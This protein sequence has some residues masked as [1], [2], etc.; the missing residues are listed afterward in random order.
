DDLLEV[1]R[2]NHGTTDAD[3]SFDIDGAS[4]TLAYYASLGRRLGPRHV[5]ADGDGV[6]LGKTEGFYARHALVPRQGVAVAINAFNF[7]VWGFAEKAACALLAGMPMVVKPATATALVTERALRL[8]IEAEILPEGALQ[9]ICGSTGDLLD[10]LGPQDVLAFTGSADTALRLRGRQNLLAASTH[11]NVEAD[12]LNAAVLAPDAE[13]GSTTFEL[14]VRDVAREMTQK[15]GQKCTAV[16][17]VVVP[18]GRADAVCEA[19]AKRLGR[20]LVGNPASEGVRMGPLA[21]AGQLRDTLAGVAELRQHAE[22][23]VGTGERIDGAGSPEGKGYFF[24]PTLLRTADSGL[25]EASPGPI[26]TREVFG[27]VATLVPYGGSAEEG[28]AVVAL[29]GGTLV[30]SAYSDDSSWLE[31]FLGRAAAHTGR[32][33]V[34]SSGSAEVAFGSGAALPQA[35]HGGPGRAGG[36]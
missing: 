31:V 24:G 29:G 9:L 26:H 36:G 10:H 27:P 33:Y 35:L 6:Q 1:S 30:T 11:I 17:R 2:R 14:F 18:E 3:G 23:V 19:L 7:P 16:R 4:G 8:L 34:G 21:S 25:S 32:L 15:A 12:S 22:L 20:T 13:P 28:A 5:L